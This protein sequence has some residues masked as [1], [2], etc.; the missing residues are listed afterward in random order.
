MTVG[1][2]HNRDRQTLH[3]ILFQRHRCFCWQHRRNPAGPRGG[4]LHTRRA[5]PTR[6]K[7]R[8]W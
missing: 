7:P 5:A 1:Y 2:R 3:Y 8:M 6:G 4:S